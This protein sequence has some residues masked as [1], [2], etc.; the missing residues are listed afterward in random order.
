MASQ[1]RSVEEFKWN[2]Y[3]CAALS[4]LR[5]YRTIYSSAWTPISL[6]TILLLV[7]SLCISLSLRYDA[8]QFGL[9]SGIIP[10]EWA[11]LVERSSL[12]QF[13]KY[14]QPF[15]RI[16][17]QAA[18]HL[19][20]RAAANVY[21]SVCVCV[22][23]CRLPLHRLLVSMDRFRCFLIAKRNDHQNT[24]LMKYSM[25]CSP[26]LRYFLQVCDT[27]CRDT[28]GQC[29][30]CIE[31]EN[32]KG[33]ENYILYVSILWGQFIFV[34]TLLIWLFVFGSIDWT[35]RASCVSIC[36]CVWTKMAA[37]CIDSKDGVRHEPQRKVA[38][39]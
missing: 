27:I 31:S 23:W 3:E 11:I 4:I 25:S 33:D 20:S 21:A 12:S 30:L 15:C 34:I 29:A 32:V 8:S 9:F 26:F 18:D 13:D 28:Y 1:R 24:F 17:T 22:C 36:G 37:N 10:S 14:K 35:E 39:P 7:Y 16:R 19:F 6:H 5:R 2:Q 38:L